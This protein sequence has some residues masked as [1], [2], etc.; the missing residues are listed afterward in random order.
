MPSIID[1][2]LSFT[3]SA[4]KKY[5]VRSIVLCEVGSFYEVYDIVPTDQSPH[6]R[7]CRDLLGILVTRK[8]KTDDPDRPY[9]AGIPTQSVRRY[10]KILL[11]HNYTVVFVHQKGDA[12]NITR[13][14]TK[15]L[16]PGCSLSEDVHESAE[17]GQSVLVAVLIEED[18]TDG[19]CY[20]HL[21]TFDTNR[22]TTHLESIWNTDTSKLKAD[23]EI[24]MCMLTDKLQSSLFHEMCVYTRG[25][26]DKFTRHMEQFLRTWR[27]VGKLVHNTEVHTK[28]H[29]HMFQPSF[30]QQFL[31]RM[32]ASHMSP[33][34]SVWE[35]LGLQFTER[36]CVAVMVFL[37]DWVKTHDRRLVAEL[38]PPMSHQWG[39]IQDTKPHGSLLNDSFQ[40]VRSSNRTQPFNINTPCVAGSG[41]SGTFKDSYVH[42]FNELYGKL[43]VFD[44]TKRTNIH[45]E[46]IDGL[47][48]GVSNTTTSLY[49]LLN[50]TRTKMGGRLLRERF[51]H[52]SVSPE[53]MEHRWA[54]VESLIEDESTFKC[55]HTY[56]RS[57]DLERVYRRLTL[58]QLQPCE[59]PRMMESQANMLQVLQHLTTLPPT[60]FLRQLLP[61][62]QLVV[63]LSSYQKQ[64]MELF[65]ISKCAHVN[66]QN[67]Q[68]TLFHRGKFSDI[69]NAYD[70][71]VKLTNSVDELAQ[72]LM[73]QVPEMMAISTATKA[74]RLE[75]KTTNPN[76]KKQP[77]RRSKRLVSSLN[78][79]QGGNPCTSV[80][81]PTDDSE[82]HST[83]SA[84][85]DWIHVKKSDKD[86]YWLELTRQRCD[87]LR[88][89]MSLSTGNTNVASSIGDWELVFENKKTTSKITCPRLR[90]LSSD[91][92]QAQHHLVEIVRKQ[93][94]Q[95]QR[96]LYDQHFEKTI[97][98]LLKLI[99]QLDVAFATSVVSKKY[100]YIRPKI[101]YDAH[102]KGEAHLNV[103]SLRHPLIE[104]LLVQQGSKAAYVPNDVT[105]SPTH[106]WLLHGVNSVGKSS[107][108]KSIAIAV[109]MA[110]A[111]LFV[112]A[113]D[114]VFSPFTKMFARTG[115]DDNIHRAH[116][117]FV[118][119]MT[120]AK[121]IIYH[122]DSRSLVIADELCASTEL[123]S[124]VQIVGGILQL[125]TSRKTTYAFATHL[126]ALQEQPHVQQLIDSAKLGT[127]KNLHMRVDFRD[128]K[129]V[130]ERTLTAG[131]PTNRT[132]GVLVAD[133]VIQHPEFTNILR[134]M[135]CTVGSRTHDTD[136][137]THHHMIISDS[138]P[139]VPFPKVKDTCNH[140]DHTLLQQISSMS[141]SDSHST[142]QSELSKPSDGNENRSAVM[143]SSLPVIPVTSR[144][145]HGVNDGMFSNA[146]RETK[147]TPTTSKYNAKMWVD[148]C[149][150]CHYHPPTSAHVPLD[151]HHIHEQ[152]SANKM[153]GL[154][155]HRFHKNER[156]NLVVLCKPCHQAV[157]A[158]KLLIDGYVMTS[159]GAE[160]SWKWEINNPHKRVDT[161]VESSMD[162]S[163]HSQSVE[164]Y[165]S[166][167]SS[168]S[169]ETCLASGSSLSNASS[170]TNN[171]EHA[172]PSV[173]PLMPSA[174]QTIGRYTPEVVAAIR[175][176]YHSNRG[177]HMSKQQLWRNARVAVGVRMGY[178]TFW[179]VIG[180]MDGINVDNETSSSSRVGGVNKLC[181][182]QF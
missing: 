141:I 139:H 91:I 172:A 112:A 77:V 176:F 129:L 44:D 80:V 123:H 132:Y 138:S 147:P 177:L 37:L 118:K 170:T 127:L 18:D 16:S 1:Q 2:Y 117:S 31:E 56:L 135:N 161:T 145:H 90:D 24:M 47:D 124:A 95:T 41:G 126:F 144:N 100:G 74:V 171:N 93:Y 140:A 22:G 109:L 110:Q 19:E 71:H 102:Q 50:T 160:L 7:C 39:V 174:S 57:I 182:V 8:G 146:K 83:T 21:A 104:R 150:V 9:M 84:P 15:V 151:T 105:L 63:R 179:E 52:V 87:K 86:G 35:T 142:S 67:L 103:T 33:F 158:G 26:S 65:D 70:Y 169:S 81:H 43:N 130:F 40:T 121:Q 61:E 155:E 5:G 88:K 72:T 128:G 75:K 180:D 32:F 122:S 175:E 82:I 106:C 53:V 46:C 20:A 34:Q 162:G 116:S 49:S 4:H 59:I 3:A 27:S 54:L 38:S 29:A 125:L 25:T 167:S 115:N 78:G 159:Q 107:L 23:A 131:L 73:A 14:V 113:S 79:S 163:P 149:A 101:D 85:P 62:P 173:S 55:L 114:M 51:V 30:Q 136:T 111:G 108:L 45:I 69:D 96:D 94:T 181:S 165:G 66:G 48:G 76:Y 11:Q 134:N 156:H 28:A 178:K 42:C 60:H 133:K 168:L 12:P 58:G 119:E 13:E 143:T 153:T 92:Q 148:E 99:A 6:L 164:T 166:S 152:Q 137:H 154:I 97:R 68:T 64:L 120:E 157:D 89:H 17:V 36:S 98:P 10:N